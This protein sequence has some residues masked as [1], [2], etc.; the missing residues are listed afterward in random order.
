MA[1]QAIPAVSPVGWHRLRELV[2]I[3]ADSRLTAA[4]VTIVGLFVVVIEGLPFPR[5]V[6]DLDYS[7]V[8]LS[9]AVAILFGLRRYQPRTKAPWYLM[10]AGQLLWVVADT[11]FNYQ[12]D[13]LGTDAFPTVSDVFYLL[14]YVAF[15][16][17]LGRLV[18]DR[19]RSTLDMGP[20][21]DAA[22]VTAG[23]GL[24]SWVL[25]AR[26]T[27]SD[28]SN[29]PL[30]ATVAAAYPT[31]DIVL[32]GMLV[33][34]L[35]T[36]G[37]RSPAFRLLLAALALLITA[38]TLSAAFGL[39]MSNGVGG[40]E[41]L[42]LL[43]YAAWGGAAL[44]P[45]MTR[46]SET[47][48][49]PESSFK[50]LRL[51]AVVVATMVA[52]A[53]LAVQKVSGASLDVWAVV[54]GSIVMFLL[55]VVRMNLALQQIVSAHQALEDLQHE[56]AIQATHDPMTGLFNRIQTMRLL[57]GALGRARRRGNTVGL[58]FIDLDGFKLINDTHGH[59]AGDEV[60][61]QTAQRMQQEIREGDFVGRLG[62]DEFVVGIEDVTD[63]RA[64][65]ALA[66]RLIRSV[67]QPMQLT[68]DV[69]AHVGAS[70]G[71]ALGRG[72][73]TNAEGLLNEADLAVYEAKAAGR[74]RYVLFD[75]SARAALRKRNDLER[76]LAHA[77]ALD[78]LVLH[79]Q[80]IVDTLT[81]DVACY[82][83][84]V[85]WNRP[86]H[87]LVPPGDFLPTA[88]TSDLI[89]NLDVWVLDAAL[90][91]LAVWNAER[92][93]RK[94]QVSVNLSGRHIVQ[95]RV[96]ADV[97]HALACADVD[98]GQLVIEVTETVIT[99]GSLA[100]PHLEALR[101]TGVVISLDDFGTGYTSNSQ[102]SRL[103]VDILKIDRQ[104]LDLGVEQTRALL[105]LT[106]K[107]G[108]A[109]GVRVVAEGIEYQEQLDVVR[110]LGC[111]YVQGFF[112]ARPAP[113][114]VLAAI[115]SAPGALA[116]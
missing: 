40:V 56:L 51:V 80:P 36:P 61:K 10:A 112:I 3:H 35:S 16:F 62:G 20:L 46:L 79:Y 87:G 41:Y 82:E 69:I 95:R 94:L 107:V 21:L 110:D 114:E 28:L 37:G 13:V 77:I 104:F 78:E 101:E 9:V 53:I 43:S 73:E 75:G 18:L 65:I 47:G 38:D 50:G 115:D 89:C 85:R 22:T 26:P 64:T 106:V 57:A 24:L 11:S 49:A 8:G 84:L 103:P 4:Y 32:V 113:A 74:G 68:D 92:G 25:L 93:D 6:Q 39:F 83:A 58:L 15:A 99:D 108:H 63:E 14:G 7:M 33:R 52:P 55:V 72:G 98:P 29:S 19:S 60:L 86:G 81:G 1:E 71:V 76:S 34:L 12:Q 45:S 5:M 111:E 116:G 102:L 97:A 105:E 54:L 44:H 59:R 27:I 23:L 67:S 66:Q 109:F 48:T 91:Q 2:H 70:I 88:E 100:T 30:A 31:M 17:A 90:S 42:W 96:L